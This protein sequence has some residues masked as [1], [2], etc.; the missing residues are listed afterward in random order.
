MART[1]TASP[2]GGKRLASAGQMGPTRRRAG[3]TSMPSAG[4]P[5]S[6]AD[7]PAVR[8]IPGEARPSRPQVQ[9]LLD[10]AWLLFQEGAFPSA[11]YTARQAL[12]AGA[13]APAEVLLGHI[14]RTIGELADAKQAYQRALRLAPKDRA[15]AEGLRKTQVALGELSKADTGPSKD[16][17]R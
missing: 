11:A 12:S 2:T 13:G 17:Y 8:P 9:A 15:A 6:T 3:A 16:S 7:K 5:V 14:Y 10:Q 1:K 4:A